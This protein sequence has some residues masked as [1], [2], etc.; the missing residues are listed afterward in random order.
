M[1]INGKDYETVWMEDNKV[2]MIEQRKLPHKFEVVEYNDYK[3]VANAITTMVVRGAPAIGASGAYGLALTAIKYEGIDYEGFINSVKT[4]KQILSNARPT[5]YDLFHGLDFVEKAILNTRSIE[6]GKNIARLKSREYAE[7]SINNCKK[8]GEYGN[9]LIKEGDKILTHCNAGA[10]A[11]VDYGTALAPMRSAKEGGKNIFVFADETRPRLQGSLLTAFELKEEG[12][13][14]AIIADNAAGHYMKKGEI[15]LCIVGA[16][17]I[18]R[19]GDVANKIGTYE[20]AVLAKENGIPFYVAAPL[21]TVDFGCQSGEGIPI[22]ERDENEVLF[23]EG[24]K[25]GEIFKVRA[26]NKDSHAKN[27]AFDVTP[28]KYI[29]KIITEV[30]LIEPSELAKWENHTKERSL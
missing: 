6:D 23:V 22:E 14:H 5:A 7:W 9:T 21:T 10:L 4:A 12:I 18:A 30:G 24:E 15:N 13:S 17:R 29:T 8:I 2:K 19:N 26:S 20:K 11:T 27:P 1:K 25:D 3:E 16:D 28:A